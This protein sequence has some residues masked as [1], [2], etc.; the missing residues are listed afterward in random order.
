[1]NIRGWWWQR[2]L[3]RWWWWWQLW[4]WWRWWPCVSCCS[5]VCQ[6]RAVWRTR[7][8]TLQLCVILRSGWLLVQ[9]S[10]APK[11]RHPSMLIVIQRSAPTGR[12]PPTLLSSIIYRLFLSNR[13]LANVDDT[14]WGLYPKVEWKSFKLTFSSSRFLF[15]HL[16]WNT[17]P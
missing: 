8:A 6:E 16:I 1:M 7:R 10:S 4:W 11:R 14:Y 5:R 17:K 12:H 13:F 2:Q 9:S 3:Q 15:L